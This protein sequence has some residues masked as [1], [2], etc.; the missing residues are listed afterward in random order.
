LCRSSLV[1]GATV[2]LLFRPSC[3]QLLASLKL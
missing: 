3:R 1:G 2:L